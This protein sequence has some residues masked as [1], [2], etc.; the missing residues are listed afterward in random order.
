MTFLA[1]DQLQITPGKCKGVVVTAGSRELRGLGGTWARATQSVIKS[2]P[3]GE[4]ADDKK[5][6]LSMYQ[7]LALGIQP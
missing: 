7:T 1:A 6:P 2:P 4:S 5:G 3:F